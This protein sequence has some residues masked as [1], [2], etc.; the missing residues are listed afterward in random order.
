MTQTK[1]LVRQV[2][3]RCR[4]A[5]SA[6]SP[7]SRLPPTTR[8]CGGNSR[9]L[10]IRLGDQLQSRGRHDLRDVVHLRPDGAPLWLVVTA[11]RRR[12]ACT[13]AICSGRRGRRS[14][15]AVQSGDG[16][17][18]KVGTATFTF[19][20]GNNATFD[21]TVQLADMV[22]PVRRRRRSRARSSPHPARSASR[23][24][25]NRP[26]GCRRMSAGV[27]ALNARGRSRDIGAPRR[28]QNCSAGDRERGVAAFGDRA[29]EARRARQQAVGVEARRLD[30]GGQEARVAG[31][32]RRCFAATSAARPICQPPATRPHSFEIR[33][34]AGVRGARVR[35][36]GG[37]DPV[38]RLRAP[39]R[40]LPPAARRS[41]SRSASAWPRELASRP[42]RSRAAI[43]RATAPPSRAV[44]RPIRSF[45]W[46]PVVPS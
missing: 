44:L 19:A 14:A 28:R 41:P 18:T 20:D 25:I 10:R 23:R 17:A 13:P 7:I 16:R 21:Y 29:R 24:G 30:L 1:T 43:A 2:F 40:P 39:P 26:L 12:P 42:S 11:T 37:H 5:C 34:G 33:H 15:H 36:V 8:I 27:P 3:G 35:A 46:M 6:R 22:A 45:A 31:A 32:R 38:D 9:P 4:R